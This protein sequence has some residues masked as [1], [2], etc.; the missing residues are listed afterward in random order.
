MKN[1]KRP[2]EMSKRKQDK[3]FAKANH[4]KLESLAQSEAEPVSVVEA[5]KSLNVSQRTVWN[6]IRKGHVDKIRIGHK[7]YIPSGSLERFARS[8]K[9][10]SLT[11]KSKQIQPLSVS[12]A[13]SSGKAVVEV[14]YLQEL[15]T[16]LGQLT[17][18][19]QYLL[20]NQTEQE[21]DKN[22][23]IDAKARIVELQTKESETKSMA[24]IL[25]KE[26]KYIR[27]MLWIFMGVG[28]SLII[29]TVAFLIK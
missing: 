29:V 27:T 20:E 7:V 5:A 18:E 11:E 3:I 17:A 6:Y 2:S 12:K 13:L 8:E 28:L 9:Q 4:L 22:E 10:F 24:V 1:W 21:N 19:K 23:L 14:A 26:N 25:N 16:R 15:W